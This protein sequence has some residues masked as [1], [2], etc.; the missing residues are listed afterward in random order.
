MH[1]LSTQ[2]IIQLQVG[3]SIAISNRHGKY[4]IT[5]VKRISPTGQITTEEGRRFTRYGNEIGSREQLWSIAHA[6]EFNASYDL[7]VQ[8]KQLCYQVSCEAQRLA[9]PRNLRPLTL[10]QLAELHASLVE[11]TGRFLPSGEV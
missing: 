7:G 4:I 9:E 3:D 6:E 11:L 8:A 1:S 5:T 10:E 2:E